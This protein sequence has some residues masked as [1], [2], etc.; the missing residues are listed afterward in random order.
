MRSDIAQPW[1]DCVCSVRR[2]S[3]S[4]VPGRR[5]GTACRDMVSLGDTTPGWCRLST[6][7]KVVEVVS[8]PTVSHALVE[9]TLHAQV[10]AA[11]SVPLNDP[12]AAGTVNGVGLTVQPQPDDG[13]GGGGVLVSS[14]SVALAQHLSPVNAPAQIR[15]TVGTPPPLRVALH[16]RDVSG[17]ED[18]DRAH[19]GRDE[20]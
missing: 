10:D 11:V 16:D 13:G 1:S 19:A 5:S 8:D 2:M 6:P 4:R 20:R 18:R 3:R 17:R 9:Y 14:V 12:P 7:I 15:L